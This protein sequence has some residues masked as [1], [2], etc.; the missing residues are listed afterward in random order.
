LLL[1]LINKQNSLFTRWDEIETSWSII[2][3]VKKQ[4]LD[5][6]IYNNYQE[7]KEKIIEVSGGI[8]NDL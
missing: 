5:I 7:L 6:F 4:Q 8:K 3:E 1:D 2:D